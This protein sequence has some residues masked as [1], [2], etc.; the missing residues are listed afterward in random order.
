MSIGMTRSGTLDDE[1]QNDV[2]M[3]GRTV[4]THAEQTLQRKQLPVILRK[5]GRCIE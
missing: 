1:V 2:S 3:R 4:N 5:E